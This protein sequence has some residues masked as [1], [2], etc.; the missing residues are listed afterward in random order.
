MSALPQPRSPDRFA[1]GTVE[2]IAVLRAN[3]LGDF[4]F[5]LPALRALRL[6]FPGAQ[7]V[8]LGK[9]WHKR[10]LTGRGPLV[11]EVVALPPIAGVGVPPGQDGR[12]DPRAVEA[13][14]TAL[15]ERHFDLAFQMHGGGRYSNPFVRQLGAPHEF[16]LHTPDAPPLQHSVPYLRL[17]NERLRLLEVVALA[18]AHTWELDPRLPVLVR[19]EVELESVVRL[20]DAPMVVLNPGATD[21]RR[22]WPPERFARVGDLLAAEGAAVVLHGDASER[23]L[24]AA[25]AAAMTRPAIDLGGKLSLGGLAALLERACVVVANDSGP[26]HLAQAVGAATVGL[27]W[28]INLVISGPPTAARRRVALSVTSDC[29]VCGR[30]NTLVRCEHDPCFVDDIPVDEV[31]TLTLDLWR[32]E[33]RERADRAS[34]A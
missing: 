13:C 14:C 27:Y 15:R 30:D 25:I 10:F 26:L 22:R 16:G 34:A 32:Q 28:L 12:H 31:V 7:M 3:G 18:G 19:D 21:P 11:D 33:R 29:P 5:T 20:P 1:F 23:G 9:P 4:I 24:T 6:R 17:Q 2:R 8:L